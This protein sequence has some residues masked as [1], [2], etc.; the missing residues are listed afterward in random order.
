MHQRGRRPWE[1]EV[2]GWG[3]GETTVYKGKCG[4]QVAPLVCPHPNPCD[5]TLPGKE[6]LTG[7]TEVITQRLKARGILVQSRGAL[8]TGP[9]VAAVT[10][11]R[12]GRR[13][14]KSERPGPAVAGWKTQGQRDGQGDGHLQVPVGAPQW[15][16]HV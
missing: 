11:C 15:V 4:R 6:G 12:T 1:P 13:D 10:W 16:V 3:A 8:E 9:H 7:V 5:N 2:G 14:S